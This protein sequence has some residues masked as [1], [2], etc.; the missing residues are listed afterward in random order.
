MWVGAFWRR[1]RVGRMLGGEIGC[2]GNLVLGD[3]EFGWEPEDQRAF[4]RLL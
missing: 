1:E 4:V 3:R 2:C